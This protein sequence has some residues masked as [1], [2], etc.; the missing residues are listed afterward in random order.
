MKSQWTIQNIP[1]KIGH[2]IAAKL[3]DSILDTESINN[4][5][6]YNK[7]IQIFNKV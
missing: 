1:V 3:M 7:I 5:I 2:T 6:N 4:I